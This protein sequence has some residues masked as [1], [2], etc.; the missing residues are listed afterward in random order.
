MFYTLSVD[1]ATSKNSSA[2]EFFGKVSLVST[3]LFEVIWGLIVFVELAITFLLVCISKK[4]LQFN[5]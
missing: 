5:I 4:H 3:S 1:M 2:T